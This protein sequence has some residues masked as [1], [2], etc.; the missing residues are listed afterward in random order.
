MHGHMISETPI[1]RPRKPDAEP[2]SFD[3]PASGKSAAPSIFLRRLEQVRELSETERALVGR[4]SVFRESIQAG[5]PFWRPGQ[6]VCA[7]VIISGWACRQ[8]TLPDGRRQIF[9]FLLPGDTVGLNVNATALDQISTVAI[10]RVE[11]MDALMLRE[12][13]TLGDDRYARL[14]AA[15]EETRRLQDVYLLNHVMRLGRQSALERLAHLILEIQERA[16][17]AGLLQGGRFPMPLTQE[18]LSD[19]LGL[20][21][22]HL[23][24]TLQ[25]LK[26]DGLIEI[27]S[28]QV[29]VLDPRRLETIADYGS[30]DD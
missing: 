5:R 9:G 8:R 1:V 21:I 11:S 24:R 2:R 14:S 4:L 19:A 26:R 30:H 16:R 13:L 18:V 25:Q 17:H 6:A 12:I 23:N 28:G 15:V 27:K 3:R 22:V 20:S 7:R 29:A 10:N